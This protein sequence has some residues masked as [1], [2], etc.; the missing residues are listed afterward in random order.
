MK[1][2]HPSHKIALAL[3]ATIL[4]AGGAQAYEVNL[5]KNLPPVDFHGFVSQGFLASTDYDYLGNTTQGSFNFTEVGLNLS[6]NPLPRTRIAVQGFDFTVGRVNE[7][8]P[9]LDYALVEYTFNDYIGVRAG[10]IRRP[11]GFYNHIQD[12]DLARTSVLLP[13]GIYDARWRDFS[14]SIDGGEF[15]GNLPLG[16]AGSLSYE[17]Y[18]GLINMSDKGGVARGI[19]NGLP[20]APIGSFGGIDQCPI[21]GGQLWYNTPV[22]GLR[23]G[24]SGG[25][26]SDFGYTVTV[27][28]PFG[29]GE[30]KTV[31]DIPYGQVSLEYLW[32]SWTF[33]AEYFTYNVV[34]HKI[35][36]GVDTGASPG[37]QTE[38]WYV[39]AAYRFN[40]WLEVGSYYNEYY[41]DTDQ[42]SNSTQYQKDVAL[43][44]RVDPKDWWVFKIEGHYI[45]GTGLLNDNQQSTPIDDRGWFMLA[46]KS[47][48]SF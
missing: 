7:Y 28:P 46:V 27:N 32:K 42:T 30:I 22:D 23:L 31:S 20:P 1:V 38:S 8:E 3:T 24:L 35:I 41:G 13:Q 10:R 17:V 12:V 34:G 48:F 26:I 16:K 9:F 29:P 19:Q 21:Y 5:G 11:G 15:F 36:G 4:A 43:S 45:T 37:V 40:K 18:A 33:Q 2:M 14:C 6:V 25:Y 44:V 39:S 47:T